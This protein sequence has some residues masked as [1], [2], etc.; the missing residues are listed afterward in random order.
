MGRSS[1]TRHDG[2]LEEGM[3]VLP[4]DECERR[5]ARGGVGILAMSGADTP[6]VRPVNF[7]LHRGRIWIRTGEGRIL[8]AGRSDERASFVLT[9]IDRF[10]HTG[11]SVVVTGQLSEC[12]EL[13][14]DLRVRPWARGG[15]HHFVTLAI[16]RISG[17]RIASESGAW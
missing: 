2:D 8:A 16:D 13:D 3:E 4:L 15:R 14:E 12:L 7:A 9:E 10:E 5:L 1:D 6:V 11:W 17:R